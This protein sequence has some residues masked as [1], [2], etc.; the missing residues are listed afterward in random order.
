MATITVDTSGLVDGTQADAADVSIPIGNLKTAVE[1]IINGIQAFDQ[2][3][4]GSASTLTLASDTVTVTKSFHLIDT[5]ASASTDNLATINGGSAGDILVFAAANSSRDVVVKHGTGNI[6][7][8]SEADVTLTTANMIIIAVYN[9]TNWLAKG[10]GGGSLSSPPPIGNVAPNTVAATTL[11]ATT[12]NI[13]TVNGI[14]RTTASGAG[15]SGLRVPAGTPPTSP[16]DG[17]IFNNS[18]YANMNTSSGGLTGSIAQTLYASTVTIFD[19][20]TAETDMISGSPVGSR[21]F[22]ANSLKARNIFRMKACGVLLYTGTPTFTFRMRIASTD[23][24][25]VVFTMP[26]S[27]AF[28]S[29]SLECFLFVYSTGGSGLSRTQGVWFQPSGSAPIVRDLY[30]PG[31]YVTIDTTASQTLEMTGQ[32][33][34]SSASNQCINWLFTLEKMF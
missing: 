16:V 8:D 17:D 6:K 4:L 11:T 22:P 2:A 27:P 15:A 19:T 30:P 7:I 13:T 33:S 10:I 1:N 25:S 20:T 21:V 18:T 31:G 23:F 3:N 26:A 5:E 29:Y 34:V 32:W 9:G 24:V 28:Y 12:G 14:V